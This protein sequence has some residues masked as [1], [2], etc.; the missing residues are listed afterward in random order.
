MRHKPKLLLQGSKA[1]EV[2]LQEDKPLLI[3]TSVLS[4]LSEVETFCRLEANPL[5]VQQPGIKGL[6]CAEVALT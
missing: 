4:Q 6:G 2:Y 5:G 1:V 3:K